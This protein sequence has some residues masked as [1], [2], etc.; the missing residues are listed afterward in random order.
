M[1]RYGSRMRTLQGA[2]RRHVRMKDWR[3]TLS[4]HGSQRC[5]VV[6][7]D[8]LVPDTRPHTR[9]FAKQDRKRLG[10]EIRRAREAA[11]HPYRPSFAEL[12]GPPLGVRSLL[13]LEN[14]EPVSAMVYEAAGRTLGRLYQDWSVEVP[15]QILRGEPAPAGVLLPDADSSDPADPRTHDEQPS[16]ASESPDFA[17]EDYPDM[18]DFLRVVIKNLRNQ[19]VPHQAIMS[20][21]AKIVGDLDR[22]GSSTDRDDP[23]TP[24]G[25]VG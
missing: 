10:E 11:G 4:G 16:S 25:Q 22:N 24:R 2:Y 5:A 1:V 9:E 6:R 19:G 21:V 13:K 20:A 15:L 8:S 17:P 12:A 18:E 23:N 7:H 3:R 14:G